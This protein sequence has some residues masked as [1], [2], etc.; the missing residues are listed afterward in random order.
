VATT[1]SSARNTILERIGELR[2]ASPPVPRRYKTTGSLDAQARIELFGERVTDYR[3]EVRHSDA[4]DVAA[5]L[6]SILSARGATTFAVPSEL[7]DDWR[8]PTSIVGDALTPLELDGIDG[9][10]TGCTVAIA[11]TGTIVMTSGPSEGTRKL[12][13]VP[14]LHICIVQSDQIV[15]TVPEGISAVADIVRAERRPV[16]LISGPSA[17]SDIELSRV[18]GVHGPR[19]L[20]VLIV[21]T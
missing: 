11:E 7:P 13:L 16:T 9:V 2:H 15:E 14:D 10:V 18:E 1:L 3:A 5:T 12:T 4:G 20:V 8:P 21:A 17:T 6:A 19:Q